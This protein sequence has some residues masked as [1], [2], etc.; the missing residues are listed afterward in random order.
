MDGVSLVDRL[1]G[2]DQADQLDA[3]SETGIWLTELPGTPKGHLR[4]PDLQDLLTVQSVSSG[5]ISVKPEYSE[6]V[7]RAKD[8]MIRH[9]RWKLVYQP[10]QD[11]YLLKLYN[12]DVDPECSVDVALQYPH[13]V[14]ILWPRLRTWIYS[15]PIM[16]KGLT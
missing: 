6:L 10:L 2:N 11:N 13:I 8:R 9:G 15:D 5:T 1:F 3:Y 12:T 7:L 14:D 4:Y 16:A